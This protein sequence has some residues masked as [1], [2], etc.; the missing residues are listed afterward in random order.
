LFQR[1]WLL[2]VFEG[3]NSDFDLIFKELSKTK[4]ILG[5]EQ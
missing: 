5:E 1:S 4:W 3:K 2:V